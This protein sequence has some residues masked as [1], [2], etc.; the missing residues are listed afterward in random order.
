MIR[1]RS[2]IVSDQAHTGQPTA[3][4]T[5]SHTYHTFHT[6]I[7]IIFRSSVF[8]RFFSHSVLLIHIYINMHSIWNEA[9]SFICQETGVCKNISECKVSP[10]TV[11][12][13]FCSELGCSTPL[14]RV[15]IVS[16]LA[17][18][19]VSR[20]RFEQHYRLLGSI[21]LDSMKVIFPAS[22]EGRAMHGQRHI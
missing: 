10:P 1:L 8:P 3:G 16:T 15:T 18:C 19:S 20:I 22:N 13:S 14:S 9:S 5:R 6:N 12:F 21:F 11:V 2:G 7:Y 17:T 4:F